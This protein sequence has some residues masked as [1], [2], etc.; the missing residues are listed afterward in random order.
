MM[1]HSTRVQFERTY[2]FIYESPFILR[3]EDLATVWITNNCKQRLLVLIYILF[4]PI[5]I[6]TSR[7]F[8]LNFIDAN[9]FIADGVNAFAQHK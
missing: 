6:N 3:I 9:E 2:D 5:Y 8:N 1:L 7:Y 4:I